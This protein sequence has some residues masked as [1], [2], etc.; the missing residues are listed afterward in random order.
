LSCRRVDA[1]NLHRTFSCVKYS[2]RRLA[3]KFSMLF[4]KRS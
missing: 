4:S 3:I 2:Y 1:V